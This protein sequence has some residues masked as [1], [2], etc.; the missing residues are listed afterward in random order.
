MRALG[1]RAG[2]SPDKGGRGEPRQ[3]RMRREAEV[4][5]VPT[6]LHGV[7]DYV[8]ATA[9]LAGAVIYGG[10]EPQV[11][12]AVP[13]AL[14]VLAVA[15]VTDFEWGIVRRLPVPVH[16]AL[17]LLIG[18]ALAASPWVLGFAAEV[19]APHVL[20]GAVL[21]GAALTTQPRPY[22][23]EHPAFLRAQGRPS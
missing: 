6:R 16:M 20:A 22:G 23:L 9:M 2:R 7:L 15:M 12:V 13:A 1:I 8:L 19:W 4:Q 21:I 11:W 10:G 3:R 14:A 5:Y 18:G 17:D